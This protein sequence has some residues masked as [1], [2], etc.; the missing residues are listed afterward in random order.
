MMD[1][2]R[3]IEIETRLAFQEHT[4]SEL[5]DLVHRQRLELDALRAALIQATADL[6]ALRSGVSSP[7]AA[8]EPPPHY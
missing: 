5:S 1:D 2:A 7:S 8:N 3:L 4:L 6:N